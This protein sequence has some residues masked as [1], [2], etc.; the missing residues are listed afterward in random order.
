MEVVL[1]DCLLIVYR[2]G[3]I[4][5]IDRRNNKIIPFNITKNK[6]GYLCMRIDYKKVPIHKIVA[7]VYL[8]YTAGVAPL[9]I[10]EGNLMEIIHINHNK[11]D[12]HVDNLLVK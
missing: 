6:H 3:L 8:G 1:K 7:S 2:T 5:K 11:E 4:E 12:N 9:A 10:L